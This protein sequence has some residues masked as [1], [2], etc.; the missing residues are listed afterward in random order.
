VTNDVAPRRARGSGST[1]RPLRPDQRRQLLSAVTS[2]IGGDPLYPW[3]TNAEQR[4]VLDGLR[5]DGRRPMGGRG[6]RR[7][8]PD[9]DHL[10]HHRLHQRQGLSSG[11]SGRIPTRAT[12]PLSCPLHTPSARPS[13]P[14]STRRAT[15]TAPLP[16]WDTA[17]RRLPRSTTLSSP[18]WPRTA[19][20]SSTARHQP[21]ENPPGTP[22][23][24]A[25]PRRRRARMNAGHPQQRGQI[26]PADKRRRAQAF[27]GVFGGRFNTA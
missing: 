18:P 7:R 22:R 9:R 19:P 23:R 15:P 16:S 11:R 26:H 5:C 1:R 4:T 14:S 6:P 13:R 2:A 8:T 3:A 10:R 17:A 25:V 21:D 12:G 27:M 24:W 20:T